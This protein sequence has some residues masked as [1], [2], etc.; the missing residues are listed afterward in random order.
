[1][2][3]NSILKTFLIVG[4]T[5]SLALGLTGCD[6]DD[7]D[8]ETDAAQ[9]PAPTSSTSTASTTD[10]SSTEPAATTGTTSSAQ[11]TASPEPAAP[12]PAPAPAATTAAPAP[13]PT[14]FA[15]SAASPFPSGRGILWKPVSHGFNG[16]LVVL[17]PPSIAQAG[18]PIRILN[19]NGG[20]I[21]QAN[22][23]NAH[24]EN[25]GRHHFIF[26][27]TGSAYPKP[28]ILSIGGANYIIPNPGARYE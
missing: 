22:Y 16:R 1:M 14:G 25:G 17:I 2:N 6:T 15:L 27:R 24:G 28:S 23:H 3:L 12:A 20:P 26:G 21:D 19:R 5:S 9:S 8:S 10:S 4:F 18:T 13:A 11:T 7:S